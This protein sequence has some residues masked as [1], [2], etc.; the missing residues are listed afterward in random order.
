MLIKGEEDDKWSFVDIEELV[1]LKLGTIAE[2]AS[3]GRYDSTS[4]T[5]SVFR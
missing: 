2:V 5:L 1:K 4:A 3:S